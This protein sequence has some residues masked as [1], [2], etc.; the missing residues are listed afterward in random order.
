MPAAYRYPICGINISIMH[1]DNIVT[2]NVNNE[3]TCNHFE[4]EKYETGKM[5]KWWEKRGGGVWLD[6]TYSGEVN[7]VEGETCIQ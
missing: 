5:T 7:I 3:M 1:V 6:L 2:N 4:A